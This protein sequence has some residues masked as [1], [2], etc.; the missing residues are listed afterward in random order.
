MNREINKDEFWKQ[1]LEEAG[2]NIRLSVYTCP[3]EDWEIINQKHKEVIQKLVS[4]KVLDVGCGYGRLSNWFQDYTGIDGSQT[5]IK[6]AQELYPNKKFLYVDVSRG[7]L[8]SEK[9][10]DWA[11]CIS[12]KAIVIRELGEDVWKSILKELKRIAKKVLILEYSYLDDYE[13]L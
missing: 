11:V 5:F 8:F 4:G 1:R 7:T 10:F 9:E 12:L 13:L 2:E 3:E 6:K